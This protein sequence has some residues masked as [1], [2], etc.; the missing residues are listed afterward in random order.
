MLTELAGESFLN[1]VNEMELM[2]RDSF[3]RVI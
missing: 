1:R 2:N 3:K